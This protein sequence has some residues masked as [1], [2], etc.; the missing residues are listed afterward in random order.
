MVGD[1]AVPMDAAIIGCADVALIVI[2]RVTIR[3]GIGHVTDAIIVGHDVFANGPVAGAIVK[4]NR[5]AHDVRKGLI[6]SP[7][8]V[9]INQVAGCTRD[10]MAQFMGHHIQ[11]AG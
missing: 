7:R 1:A 5:R 9:L 11:V 10:A 8:F 2:R 4:L 6:Q 3:T